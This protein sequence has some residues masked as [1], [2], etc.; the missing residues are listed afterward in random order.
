MDKFSLSNKKLVKLCLALK[1]LSVS[2]LLKTRAAN[3]EHAVAVKICVIGGCPPAW[4]CK[5]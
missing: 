1:L 2:A 4:V 3:G 5:E